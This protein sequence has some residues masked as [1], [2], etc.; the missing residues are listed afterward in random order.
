M[1]TSRVPHP[2]EV[3][4]GHGVALACAPDAEVRADEL[5]G[6]FAGD[7]R[8][9]ST[10]RMTIG[11]EKW[12]SLGRS[13]LACGSAQ[14]RFQSPAI[15]DPKG[16]AISE[17]VLFL[18][19]ERRIAGALHDDLAIVSY[20]PEPVQTSLVVQLDADFADVFEVKGR[21]VPSR[22]AVSRSYGDGELRL[23]YENE[24]FRRAVHITFR[25]S[26]PSPYFA[27]SSIVFDLVLPQGEEWTCC[28]HAEPEVGGDVLRFAGD[29]HER[30]EDL[31]GE[32][33]PS[34]SAPIVLRQPFE[35]GCAD[36]VAL[37]LREGESP[38]Y[39]AAGVPWF[40]TLFGRD[41]LVPSVMTG[42]TGS[43]PA[44]E[45]LA[46]LGALQERERDDWRD[47][48]PG[49]LAHELRRGELASLGVVPH[50]PYSGSHDAPALYCLT[51]WN[52]W[53]WTGDQALLDHHLETARAA[54]RWCDELGDR[55]GDGLQEYETRSRK[56]Y[57]N[58]SWKDSGDAILH[59][60]GRLA[61]TP[62]ATVELQGYLYAA[63]LAMAELEEEVGET[64][65]A[66]RLRE[67]AANLRALVEE[68]YWLREE[69]F[70]AMA[71]D[72]RKE[73]VSSIG[74]NPGQLLWTGLPTRERA[75]AVTRRL[76][77][78]DMFTGWGIRT[79]SSDHPRY[80]ALSYQRGSV[81]PHDTALIAAGMWRYGLRD[82]AATVLR[83][84]LEAACAFEDDRLPELFCG[85]ARSLGTPVPYREANV[86]QSWAAAAPIL[87]TQ[88]FLGLVPDAPHGRCFVSPT[89][90]DW[91]TELEVSG[92]EIGDGTLGIALRRDG[93]T[94]A[95]DSLTSHRIDVAEEQTRGP[96]WAAPFD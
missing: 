1:S 77:A 12:Q 48:E 63:R 32:T 83:S 11:G 85:F 3:L 86:P 6:L 20:A 13:R 74:S 27:G 40:Y 75:S 67:A 25:T 37:A 26:G 7:T 61:E 5:H 45:S 79:L 60:D 49:K 2:I 50:T 22:L 80:N 33:A 51:L 73:P 24:D 87:A 84:I 28:I 8:V 82:E 14:W 71:V 42:L 44:R 34:V 94:T 46:A 89:L 38:P 9:L 53:R 57:Y 39:V 66:E 78:D 47:A 92:I 64:S 21:T 58:Q 69:D 59:A 65:T 91:L 29:P 19:I 23:A 55:D 54:L 35:R 31:P 56:G 43:W 93:K 96:L 18:R 81:W 68:R 90:P 17:A 70:Y 15:R 30:E 16:G 95:V 72:G 76:L 36:L 10:Y 4:F 88:L 62:L 41:S 52:A